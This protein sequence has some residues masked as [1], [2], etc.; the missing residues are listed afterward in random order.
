[1]G[2]KQFRRAELVDCQ[3]RSRT[4]KYNLARACSH[5]LALSVS[6]RQDIKLL[7]VWD[8]ENLQIRKT[9]FRGQFIQFQVLE[10]DWKSSGATSQIKLENAGY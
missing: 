9:W 7:R 1:M 8:L 10:L 4:E 6:C 3:F 2:K 5:T